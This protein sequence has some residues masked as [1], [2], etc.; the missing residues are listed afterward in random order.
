VIPVTQDDVQARL[1][2]DLTDD[3]AEQFDGLAEE[4]NA[5]VEGYLAI[6]YDDDDTVPRPVIVVT[7]RAIAR[8]FKDDGLPSQADSLTRGMGPFSATT[9]LV[10]DSTSGGPWL[11]KSDK[12]ALEPYRKGGV[13]SISLT[14]EDPLVPVVP[15]WE[16]S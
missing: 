10:A 16:G 7:S 12:M 14:R 15:F 2:R 9:H 13:S 11:T 8:M 3:E 4:A 6:V 5:L 1:R